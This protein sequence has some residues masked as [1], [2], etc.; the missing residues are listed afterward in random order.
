MVIFLDGLH[1]AFFKGDRRWLDTG[2]HTRTHTRHRLMIDS[3]CVSN[4][5]DHKVREPWMPM[6][7]VI[8]QGTY[9]VFLSTHTLLCTLAWWPWAIL[10]FI[11]GRRRAACLLSSYLYGTQTSDAPICP[12]CN[13]HHCFKSAKCGDQPSALRDKRGVLLSCP[14]GA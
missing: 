11:S 4:I 8:M 12:H 7:C 9:F 13:K 5:R 14:S 2:T 6:W 3:V 10:L 1:P